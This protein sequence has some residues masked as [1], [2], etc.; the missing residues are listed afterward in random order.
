MLEATVQ[1]EEVEAA[2]AVRLC[3]LLGRTL[4]S[5]GATTQRIQDSVRWLARHLGCSVEMLVSYDALLITAGDG[6]TYRTR[7][8]S[9]REVA[10]LN[11][12]GL[13]KVSRLLRGIPDALPEPAALERDLCVIRDSKP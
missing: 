6:T 13:A 11:L 5:F 7:I 4:F 12:S 1:R 3:L 10:G 9:S 8:D 2:R